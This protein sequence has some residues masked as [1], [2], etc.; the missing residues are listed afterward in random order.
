MGAEI[1]YIGEHLWVGQWGHFL[2]LLAFVSALFSAYSFFRQKR[3]ED[4][5]WQPYARG[6]YWVHAISVCAVIGLIFY[7]MINHMYEYDYV[8]RTVSD[9]SETRYLLAAFWADQEGSFLLWMFWHCILGLVFMYKSKSWAPTTMITLGLIQAFLTSMLLGLY[10]PFTTDDIKLGSNPFVL[11]RDVF[12]IPL[13]ANAD[14]LTLIEGRG[15]NP[16]LQ[17]YWMTIHPPVLFLGFASLSIPFCMTIGALSETRHQDILRPLLKWSLWGA[18]IY[19]LGILMGAAWAYEAL[20]FGGYWAWDPVENTS[21]VPWLLLV[22]GIHTNLIAR[23]TGYSIKTTYVYY[24]LAFLLV[25][26]STFLTRSGILGDTSVHAFTTMGLETQL[27]LFILFFA[28]LSL[29]K[30]VRGGRSV[31]QRPQEES[32]YSREFWMFIGALVLFFSGLLMTVATSLPVY[33]KLA[34]LFDPN[35]LPIAIDDP[36]VH[37]NKYQIWIG[38]FIGL[39]SG[40]TILLRYRGAGWVDYKRKYLRLILICLGSSALLTLAIGSTLATRNWQEIAFLFAGILTI[41]SNLWYLLVVIKG[42]MTMSGAA[43]SHIGFGLLVMGILFSGLNKRTITSNPFVQGDFVEGSAQDK[44]LVLIRDLPFYSKDYWMNY[45]GDTLVGNLRHYKLEFK[46]VNEKKEIIDQF[47]TYPTALYNKEFTKIAALNPGTSRGLFYD[48]FTAAAPNEHLQDIEVAKMMEDSLRY[49]SYSLVPGEHIED[50]LWSADV[51]EMVFDY[52]FAAKDH[53]ER[54]DTTSYELTIGLPITVVNK[55]TGK[56]HNIIPGLGLKEA[57]I[58]QFPEVIDELGLKFKLSDATFEQFYTEERK[59][60]YELI[61]L[62]QGASLAWQGYDIEL[63]SFARGGGESAKYKAQEGD[64]ALSAYL[65][66]TDKQ[67]YHEIMTP[68]YV[69]RGSQQFSI[70]DHDVSSGL[71]VRFVKIDPQT[72]IMS[73]QIA[74]DDRQD[75]IIEMLVAGDVPRSD[76]LIVEANIFP[77]INLV[78]LGCLMMLFGLSLSL[79]AK[80]R[81]PQN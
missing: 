69:L 2:I 38:I 81:E 42:R 8:Y 75:R 61:Q 29:W 79:Y 6:G 21:L 31:P 68:L 78:W 23:S 37:H 77:G 74:I 28:L 58:Y 73:F 41:V 44:A 62:K 22:A 5:S 52:D 36:M 13:F 3:E 59:L 72:E 19:G 10:M 9:E 67:G 39:M 53:G 56:S 66:V 45:A 12:D 64:I 35:H 76:I 15:L 55:R 24:L 60:S 1:D 30:Y 48:V 26:Y 71:H 25:V 27:V 20:T 63:L 49:L 33:N 32:I 50:S 70:K 80:R 43:L 17:N 14:Y 46:H 4:I 16:L 47:E 18:A 40:L 54:A 7:A 51:G 34:E 57:F 11:V 65:Q